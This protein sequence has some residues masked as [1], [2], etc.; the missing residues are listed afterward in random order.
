MIGVGGIAVGGHHIPG[1]DVYGEVQ[2]LRIVGHLNSLAPM[3]R[4][5]F[6]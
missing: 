3:G 5:S 4:I 6:T 1:N 2:Y